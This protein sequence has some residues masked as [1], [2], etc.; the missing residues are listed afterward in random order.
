MCSCSQPSVISH[1]ILSEIQIPSRDLKGSYNWLLPVPLTLFPAIFPL[2][3]PY[4]I[5]SGLFSVPHTYQAL[6]KDLYTCCFLCLEYS[7]PTSHPHRTDSFLS[8]TWIL[9]HSNL[10]SIILYH[11]ILFF[12]YKTY[13]NFKLYAV[14]L[15]IYHLSPLISS[16][17]GSEGMSVYTQCPGSMCRT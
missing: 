11:C 9:D 8:K 14:C 15:L 12:F 10:F 17:T 16:P 7:L 5:F 13:P 1:S 3:P 4:F 6:R 2:Y